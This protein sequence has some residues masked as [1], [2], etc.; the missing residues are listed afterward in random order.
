M[1]FQT[2]I[3]FALVAVAASQSRRENI[4]AK[5]QEAQHKAQSQLGLAINNAQNYLTSHSIDFDVQKHFNN[6]A[7]QAQAAFEAK[8]FGQQA[9]ELKKNGEA[10][11]KALLNKVENKQIRKNLAN[12][13][14]NIEAEA[15]KALNE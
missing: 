5:L 8:N 3:L 1:K 14:K 4:Q 15:K 13:L 10:R 6:A 2:T 9:Q 11:A 12:L 7:A